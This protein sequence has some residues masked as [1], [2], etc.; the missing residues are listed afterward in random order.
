M[1]CCKDWSP[2]VAGVIIFKKRLILGT[3]IAFGL[4]FTVQVST[5]PYLSLTF[6][7]P[8][9]V[10]AAEN[11]QE[12]VELAQAMAEVAP[13]HGPEAEAYVR[14]YFEDAPILVEIARCESSFRHNDPRTGEV[15]RGV[16][17]SNDLGMMQINT[18]YHKDTA[19]RLGYDLETIEGNLAYARY[20]YE[21]EGTKPWSA[22]RACWQHSEHLAIR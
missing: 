11:V 13:T 22:S 3:I 5:L 16:V 4:S 17:N 6:E 1:R 18:L 9:I 20:L 19:H 14:D 15:L 21:H 2:R 10:E 7:Q 8:T 12:V